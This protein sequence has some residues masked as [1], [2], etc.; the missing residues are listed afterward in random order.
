MISHS[1]TGRM[2]KI[3]IVLASL[4]LLILALPTAAQTTV[5]ACPA[6]A[7]SLSFGT[8]GTD[9]SALQQYLARDASIYPQGIVS[10]YFG[11]ATKAAL[12]RWQ[13]TNG[14]VKPGL[15]GS[16]TVGPRTRAALNACGSTASAV[17]STKAATLA[18]EITCNISVIPG[19]IRQ[20]EKAVVS[21]KATGSIRSGTLEGVPGPIGAVGSTTV[22]P[23]VSTAYVTTFQGPPGYSVSC[24]APLSVYTATGAPTSSTTPA[25]SSTAIVV[26]SIRVFKSD[27]SV[28]KSGSSALISWESSNASSCA[29]ESK[30]LSG[31]A[32]SAILATSTK[33]ASSLSVAPTQPTF[34]TLTCYTPLGQSGPQSAAT[35]GVGVAASGA[36]GSMLPELSLKSEGFEDSVTLPK[37]YLPRLVW[38][39]K[40]VRQF[41]CGVR[42]EAGALVGAGEYGNTTLGALA[43][44]SVYTLTCV[45][46]GGIQVTDTVRIN[47]R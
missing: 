43:T 23:S 41:S 37:G 4:P 16:G 14:I 1:Y 30:L 27:T 25:A 19:S 20:G 26:P 11:V 39:A 21:W 24:R 22:S 17:T 5:S 15:E 13:D 7:R 31:S 42:T 12:Q 40:N 47:I 34:Y 3:F 9:V 2:K 35:L 36:V 45:D 29:L 8:S 44:S 10:G 46:T 33:A 6:I 28:L 38:T 18:S 32:P